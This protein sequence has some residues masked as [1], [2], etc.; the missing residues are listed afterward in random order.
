MGAAFAVWPGVAAPLHPG[1]KTWHRAHGV[2]VKDSMV[3]IGD[4]VTGS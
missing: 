2:R 1:M 4:W 3:N